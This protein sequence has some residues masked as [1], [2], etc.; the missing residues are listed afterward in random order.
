MLT[1]GG[2]TRIFLAAEPVDM[3]KGHDGLANLV[4]GSGADLYSGHL[5]VFLSR[6]ATRIK[7]LTWERGG[8]ALY[9]KRLSKGRF[10]W[11][12]RRVGERTIAL[13][14]TQLAMLLDGIDIRGV[15]RSKAWHPP[16]AG[17]DAKDRT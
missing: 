12:E 7:I 3:R 8:L 14:S 17:I 5:F 10:R 1:V 9:Y 13:D 16:S 15:R 6:G 2:A 4:L 11:P